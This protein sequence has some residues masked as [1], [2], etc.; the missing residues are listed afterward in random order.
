MV[1]VVTWTSSVETCCAVDW[2][3]V[4]LVPFF[5]ALD[6]LS[7]VTVVVVVVV[8]LVWVLLRPRLVL[9]WVLAVLLS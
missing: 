3:L 4:V 5:V 2:A 8:V 1:D 7:V 9:V 6:F